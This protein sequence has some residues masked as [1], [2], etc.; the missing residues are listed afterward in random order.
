[1]SRHVRTRVRINLDT[2]THAHT[3]RERERK[4]GRMIWG[5]W[6]WVKRKDWVERQVGWRGGG[7]KPGEHEMGQDSVLPTGAEQTPNVQVVDSGDTWGEQKEG[8][9]VLRALPQH[10][11][12]HSHRVNP[13]D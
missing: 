3:Q 2:H 1:M 9:R 4:T 6:A 11:A 5:Q 8:D 13:R 7:S 12:V 10:R